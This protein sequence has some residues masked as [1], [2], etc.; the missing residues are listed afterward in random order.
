MVY[1][2]GFWFVFV[3]TQ[4]GSNI[5]KINAKLL[6]TH[7]FQFCEIW[8]GHSWERKIMCANLLLAHNFHCF[9]VY[10]E[11]VTQFSKR[12]VILESIFPKNSAVWR[13][14]PKN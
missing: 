6:Q 4:F 7:T 11:H 10:F 13:S 12:I 1:A 8:S 3:K 9:Y 14:I 5:K 2:P